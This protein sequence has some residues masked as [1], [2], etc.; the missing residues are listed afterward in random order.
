MSLLQ[1][2]C[3]LLQHS[4][5]SPSSSAY[6]PISQLARTVLQA[7]KFLGTALFNW[8]ALPIQ[9]A[10]GGSQVDQGSWQ[11]RQYA[12]TRER[13]K[14]VKLLLNDVLRCMEAVMSSDIGWEAIMGVRLGSLQKLRQGGQQ[15][16]RMEV[17]A[18]PAILQY[19]LLLVQRPSFKVRCSEDLTCCLPAILGSMQSL[20]DCAG[21]A[22][23]LTC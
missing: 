1:M 2:S 21:V 11:E 14:H 12:V 9:S 17:Q 7:A 20:G 13:R 18:A 4:G 16:P 5:N 3:L 19:L 10:P 8:P 23:A 22:A 6:G 15:E